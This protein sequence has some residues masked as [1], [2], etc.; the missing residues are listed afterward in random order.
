GGGYGGGGGGGSFGGGGGGDAGDCDGSGGSG[1]GGGAGSSFIVSTF[2]Q[3]A[4]HGVASSTVPDVSAS[5]RASLGSAPDSI[6]GVSGSSYKPDTTGTPLVTMTFSTVTYS[7]ARAKA[8]T[9]GRLGGVL[10]FRWRAAHAEG[11]VGFN[12]YAGLSSGPGRRLNNALIAIHAASAR[13]EYT[14]RHAVAGPYKLTAMTASG[15]QV[16]IAT[17]NG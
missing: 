10:H 6:T 12:L 5:A 4:A 8:F 15:K 3:S 1:G 7:P 11:V 16:T 13:Y 17:V 9:V 14:A 2:P